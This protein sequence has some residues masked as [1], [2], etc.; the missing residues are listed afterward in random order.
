MADTGNIVLDNGIEFTPTAW[1]PNYNLTF[2]EWLT[3]GRALLQIEASINWWVGDW[4]NYGERRYGESYSQAMEAT[5]WKYQ[6]LANA[7]WICSKIPAD[8]RHDDLSW[9]HH[10]HVAHMEKDEI[11]YWL[12]RAHEKEWDSRTLLGATKGSEP[13]ESPQDVSSADLDLEP[14]Q[15]VETPQNGAESA[16]EHSVGYTSVEFRLDDYS[17]EWLAENVKL[18]NALEEAKLVVAEG[19]ELMNIDQAV[20]WESARRWLRRHG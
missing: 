5:G 11:A 10:R 6:R 1:I 19:Y 4:L 18:R 14:T 15:A 20:R 7:R 13:T 17:D 8:L 9:T 16:T 12:D 3:A 2:D